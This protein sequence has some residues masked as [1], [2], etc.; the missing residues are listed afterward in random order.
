MSQILVVDNSKVFASVVAKKI[1]TELNFD[2]KAVQSYAEAF[3]LI[4]CGGADY[5]AA[6]VGLYIH[7]AHDGAVVD[8]VVSRNIPT[9]VCTGK[10]NDSARD[11]ILSR[12][13]IDYVLKENVHSVDSIVALVK[14]ITRNK[15]IKILVVDDS[16]SVRE[17][18]CDLLKVHQYDVLKACDGKEAGKILSKHP[19]VKMVITD[20]NMPN[21]DGFKLIKKIRSKYSKEELAIIGISGQGC[22]KL[23]AQF[24]KN[25]ANDFMTKPFLAEEFYCRITQNIEM[26]E[27][28]KAIRD[29]S[30]KDYLTGLYNRRYLF[31]SGRKL[32]ANAKR[33]NLEIAI[34]LI[35][36]DYF[37]NVNDTYGHDAGDKVLK[38]ISSILRNRFRESDIVSRF[39]GEEFC[40]MTTNM[41]H[42]HTK[43]IFDNLRAFIENL[44]IDVGDKKI[45]ITVSIG[46][47]A[48]LTDSLDK[49]IKHADIM[50]YGAKENGRNR[51]MLFQ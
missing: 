15:L 3:N 4:N 17:H 24:I 5:F 27:Y 22:N 49:M 20:Y 6:I 16:W 35:D 29:A 32:H 14:R 30:N 10:F 2:V 7:D 45:K 26:I 42:K 48:K 36:I 11:D 43:N 40:I 47:C 18:I 13:V 8:L 41:D 37:K 46:I 44:E 51:I 34:A 12:K 21:M 31:E 33:G 39:G 9:I 19:D 1:E 25:G 23:S 38:K 28:I 50:L